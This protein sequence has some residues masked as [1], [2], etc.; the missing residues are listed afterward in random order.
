MP[1]VQRSSNSLNSAS[2][3]W[4]SSGFTSSFTSSNV[5]SSNATSSSSSDAAVAGSSFGNSSSG[6][7]SLGSMFTKQD[8]CNGSV[9]ETLSPSSSS[10]RRS[11]QK[12]KGNVESQ[13]Y[14]KV[15]ISQTCACS[16]CDICLIHPLSPLREVEKQHIG[17]FHVV[18]L[19]KVWLLLVN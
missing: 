2:S 7:R 1:A 5:V 14:T 19:F 8:C 17:L 11:C 12:K 15:S 9:M 10:N 16:M 6:W 4:S 18:S 13:T 3:S